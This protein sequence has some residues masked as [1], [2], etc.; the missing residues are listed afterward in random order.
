MSYSINNIAKSRKHILSL[1][2]MRGFDISEY[3]NLSLSV[4]NDM[5]QANQLDMLVTN[6]KTQQ[7][8]YIKYHINKTLRY[9]NITEYIDDLFEY[10]AVL[11]KTDDLIII[12]KDK[13][14]QSLEKNL[15]QLWG[16]DKILI[17]VI[18][19]KAL[20][21]NIMEHDLVP[22]HKVL[23]LDEA[24]QLKKKY[25]IKQDSQLPNIS[26]FDPVALALSLRPGQICEITRKSKTAIN[27]PFYRICSV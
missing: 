19:I 2:D 9:S 6:P 5:Y 20:Q 21:F 25:N 8:A 11:K 13:I 16:Q 24:D 22:H 26:R 10:D 17:T 23:C 12:T 1:L 18:N 4:V 7:K 3:N 15:K 14:N 27:V